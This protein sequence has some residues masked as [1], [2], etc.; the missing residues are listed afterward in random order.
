MLILI[1]VLVLALIASLVFCYALNKRLKGLDG[2]IED[3]LDFLQLLNK[4]DFNARAINLGKHKIDDI[5]R[6]VNKLIDQIQAFSIEVN[7]TFAFAN[8][9]DIKRKI[10][11]EGFYPSL[12]KICT[13]INKSLDAV[14]DN[15]ILSERVQLLDTDDNKS[16]LLHL[17]KNLNVSTT[18]LSQIADQMNTTSKESTTHQSQMQEVLAAFEQLSMLIQSNNSACD[19]LARQSEDI[20]SIVG[21]IND[22]SEQT[23]LLALNAAIEAARAGEHG[24]GFAVVADEVRKLAERTQKATDEIRTNIS[25]LQENSSQVSSNSEDIALKVRDANDRVYNFSSMLNELSQNTH[26]MDTQLSRISS[27]IT[28]NLFMVDHII[29]KD[30]AYK[31]ALQVE[32]N[33]L[34]T[35]CSF[36][37]WLDEGG[38][39]YSKAP[40]YN[41]L[42]NTHALVHKLAQEALEKLNNKEEIEEVIRSFKSMEEQSVRYFKLMEEILNSEA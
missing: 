32:E 16:Q 14:Y 17:Q 10:F 2:R 3:L 30:D 39:R 36:T 18:R 13:Q 38:K 1:A 19:N 6:S 22:I 37:K 20:K 31:I 25:V 11:T 28:G 26:L 42:R 4:G 15:K 23:N 8:E 24:R 41:E 27:S 12:A 33:E 35:D 5:A 29:F 7:T 9:S 34:K 40:L 21:L